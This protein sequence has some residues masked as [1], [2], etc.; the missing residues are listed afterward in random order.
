MRPLNNET[1]SHLSVLTVD[2]QSKYTLLT[3]EPVACPTLFSYV[4]IVFSN[5][6][7]GFFHFILSCMVK[8]MA[9]STSK[10]LVV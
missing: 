7:I 6:F 2:P 8:G 4:G 1:S 5:K 9:V 3:S 10:F